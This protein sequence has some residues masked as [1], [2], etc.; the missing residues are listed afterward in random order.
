MNKLQLIKFIERFLSLDPK[1]QGKWTSF[2]IYQVRFYIMIA[3]Q[4][5][6]DN[7]LQQAQSLTFS[8]ILS[9]V[10][11]VAL[12]F[13]IFRSFANLQ[14]YEIVVQD[15]LEK[16]LL[17]SS[18]VAAFEKIKELSQNISTVEDVMSV[19]FF[20]VFSLMLF[21]TI[22][23]TINTIWR[24]KKARALFDRF[25]T[26]WILVTLGPLLI[27]VSTQIS[28]KISQVAYVGALIKSLMN[29]FPMSFIV[30]ALVFIYKLVPNTRVKWRP[31]L[32]GGIIAGILFELAKRGFNLYVLRLD[33]YNSIYAY[34][35]VA[36]FFI[37]WVYVAWIIVLFGTE[38]SYTVQNLNYL[39]EK[40]LEDRFKLKKR[41]VHYVVNDVLGLR[42]AWYIAQAFQKGSLPVTTTEITEKF[43]LPADVLEE[44]VRRFENGGIVART[45][46]PVEGLV[47]AR[48]PDTIMLTEISD[49]FQSD[50]LLS[51]PDLPL[52]NV[53]DMDHLIARME[54]ERRSGIKSV[55]LADI[56]DRTHPDKS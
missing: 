9:L 5:V 55:S 13:S 12:V 33:Y 10:P 51:N 34:L 16:H 43:D 36:I 46:Q 31:A 11:I 56:L 14:R 29:L 15:F 3:R 21:N 19:A 20:L 39:F 53:S 22:E 44:I 18:A 52:E 38:V 2:L 42:M 28:H 24:V 27:V 50:F 54:A 32:I 25:I 17:A 6:R 4:L 8:T 49:Q 45:V 7:C 48:A 47:P 37:L 26:Y 35:S 30:V 41:P 23:G 1:K 40:D